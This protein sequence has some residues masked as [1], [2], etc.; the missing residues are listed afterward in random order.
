METTQVQ[1]NG[2]DA[3]H[4]QAALETLQS[5][6]GQRL[7]R[8]MMTATQPPASASTFYTDYVRPSLPWVGVFVAGAAIGVLGMW[9][10][11]ADEDIILAAT[12]Q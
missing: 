11:G 7:V 9:Y 10:F 4:L 12:E 3:A 1:A 8:A 2:V 5:P 6:E